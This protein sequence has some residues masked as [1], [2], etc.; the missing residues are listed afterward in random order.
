MQ[1]VK[2]E[3]QTICIGMAASAAALLLASG[4]KGKRMILPNGEVLIH[5]VLGGA[6]GQATDVDI[7][8]RHILKTR[9]RLNQIL[10]KHTEQKLAKIEKDTERDYFMSAEEAKQY[11]I[12]DKVIK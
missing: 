10:V 2:P 9:D 11:G 4:K 12:V 7:H 1:Y 6:Q 8:A 3:V 5:Q